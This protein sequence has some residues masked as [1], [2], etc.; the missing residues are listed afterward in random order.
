MTQSYFTESEWSMLMQAPVQALSAVILSDKSDP[1]AFM[2]EVRAA[3]QIMLAE[4][5][6]EDLSTDL[7]RSLMQSFKDKMAAESL[8]GDELLMKKVFEYLGSI[9]NLKNASEGRKQAMNHLNEVSKILAAKVTVVQA[10]EFRQWLTSLSRKVAESVKEEGFLGGIGGERI[11]SQE[12]A[13]LRDIEK[14][15]QVI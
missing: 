3:V 7:G 4:Q 1:V 12:S 13:A 6:R 8:Q 9:A 2:K 15:L 11:S 10:N 14:A 5:Q